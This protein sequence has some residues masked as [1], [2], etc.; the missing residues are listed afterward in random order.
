MADGGGELTSTRRA[1]ASEGTKLG[2]GLDS[3]PFET[4]DLEVE[5]D[6]LV[7]MGFLSLE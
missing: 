6:R 7:M 4:D 3:D 2:D 1:E 5:D